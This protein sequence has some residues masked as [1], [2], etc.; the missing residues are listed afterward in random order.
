MRAMSA[1]PPSPL[2]ENGASASS[3]RRRYA[4]GS[5]SRRHGDRQRP[6]CP[7]ADGWSRRGSLRPQWRRAKSEV[8]WSTRSFAESLPRR[9]PTLIARPGGGPALRWAAARKGTDFYGGPRRR[10]GRD[11]EDRERDVEPRADVDVPVRAFQ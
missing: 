2:P 9:G 4:F 6:I 10:L 7:Y 5:R 8:S 3:S 11:P 1:S